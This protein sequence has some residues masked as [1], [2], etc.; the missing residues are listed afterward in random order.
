MPQTKARTLAAFMH[1]SLDGYYCDPRGDMS[2]AHKRP[3][4]SWRSRTR[5]CS[6]TDRS[7]SGTLPAGEPET[8]AMT[9]MTS[10]SKDA[11]KVGIGYGAALAIAISWSMTPGFGLSRITCA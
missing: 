4:A 1:I 11:A 10:R 5:E 7:C 2:F 8:S 9:D 6:G 3:D